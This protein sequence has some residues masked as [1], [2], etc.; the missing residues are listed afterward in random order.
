MKHPMDKTKHISFRFDPETHYKF[1]YV[2]DYEDRSGS[3]QMLYLIKKCIREFEAEH[4]PIIIE[5][6]ENG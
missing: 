6:D 2:A 5:K 3:A 4:G 1:F